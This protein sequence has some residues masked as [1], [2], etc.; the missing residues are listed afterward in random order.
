MAALNAVNVRVKV[1]AFSCDFLLAL[2][3]G[4]CGCLTTVSAF[5]HE[6][7]TLSLKDAYIYGLSSIIAA[8]LLLLAI[9]GGV[10]WTAHSA[11]L[12]SCVV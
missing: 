9:N 8:Q 12:P 10:S 7:S 11:L 2:E 4:F 5:Q 3:V 1:D 6:L